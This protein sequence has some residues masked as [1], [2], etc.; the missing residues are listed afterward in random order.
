MVNPAGGEAHSTKN[1]IHEWPPNTIES[2]PEFNFDCSPFNLT[3]MAELQSKSNQIRTALESGPFKDE[4]R[5][6][7]N[8]TRRRRQKRTNFEDP[9]TEH[10]KM[11]RGVEVHPY[12][13]ETV[14]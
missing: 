11:M 2:F 14:N 1:F 5:R 9:K 12:L 13:G 7:S 10:D 8:G 4:D 3:T 6:Q